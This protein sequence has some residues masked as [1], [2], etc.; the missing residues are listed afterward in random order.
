LSIRKFVS[1]NLFFILILLILTG[2]VL[3][4]MPPGRIAYWTRWTFLGLDKE[5]WDNLH[6]TFGFLF[7]IF[8][9]WH[10]YL[11]WNLLWRYLQSTNLIIF[12]T[13]FNLFFIVASIKNWPPVNWIVNLEEKIKNSWKV[14]KFKAPYPH[15]ELLPLDHF[16]IRLGLSPQ[17]A[18]NILERNGIKV[19]SPNETLKEISKRNN[20]PPY[21]IY[22]LLKAHARIKIPQRGN[23]RGFRKNY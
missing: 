3:Y 22:E 21:K 7:I 6:I 14:S 13:L 11:N 2:I 17:E 20:I 9:L 8:G 10:V 18:V 12:T 4:I 1:L 5:A 15:A 23:R 16:A 19:D